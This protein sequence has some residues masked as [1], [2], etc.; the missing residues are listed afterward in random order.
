[1]LMTQ[2]HFYPSERWAE[3][4]LKGCY[5]LDL[6]VFSLELLAAEACGGP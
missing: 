5:V 1:M 2:W 4:N 3:E 6:R